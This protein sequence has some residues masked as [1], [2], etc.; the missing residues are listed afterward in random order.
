MNRGT[1]LETSQN[2]ACMN[3]CVCVYSLSVCYVSAGVGVRWSEPITK[4]ECPFFL[5]LLFDFVTSIASA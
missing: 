4:N 3:V 2:D 5:S 1:C